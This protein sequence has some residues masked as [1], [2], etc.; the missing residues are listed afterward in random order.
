[1][2][3]GHHACRRE[4]PRSTGEFPQWRDH[5]SPGRTPR[6]ET[7]ARR[8]SAPLEERGKTTQLISDGTPCS[9]HL[10]RL[11]SWRVGS[12]PQRRVDPHRGTDAHKYR[13][14]A[15]ATDL[16]GQVDT[17]RAQVLRIYVRDPDDLTPC[18]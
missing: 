9:R 6:R 3:N 17:S 16:D 5:R 13:I 11:V 4:D 14:A 10:A 7:A 8:Q 1:V 12:H 18:V 2:L 15:W